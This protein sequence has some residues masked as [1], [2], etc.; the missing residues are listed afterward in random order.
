[1]NTT[2]H[3]YIAPELR[4]EPF[5]ADRLAEVNRGGPDLATQHGPAEQLANAELN[6]RV[7][8]TAIM[9]GKAIMAEKAMIATSSTD[10]S[11]ATYDVQE[12]SAFGPTGTTIKPKATGRLQKLQKA[13]SSTTKVSGAEKASTKTTPCIVWPHTLTRCA[14]Q[15]ACIL[16]RLSHTPVCLCCPSQGAAMLSM[17][18]P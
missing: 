10:P 4:S 8:E 11:S 9:A 14:S 3:P 2:H 13:R 16:C 1:M 7:A 5:T 17:P 18:R 6:D 15:Y 12:S